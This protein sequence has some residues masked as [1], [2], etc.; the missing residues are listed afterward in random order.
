LDWIAIRG[1]LLLRLL[2]LLHFPALKLVQWSLSADVSA[3]YSADCLV[4]IVATRRRRVRLAWALRFVRRPELLKRH[5][6]IA[7]PPNFVSL[8]HIAVSLIVRVEAHGGVVGGRG[9]KLVVVVVGLGPRGK[10][11]N[12]EV[13]LRGL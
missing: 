13:I 1:I 12:L 4:Y 7:K 9:V 2:R 5:V 3:D 6:S 8:G 10:E 11:V